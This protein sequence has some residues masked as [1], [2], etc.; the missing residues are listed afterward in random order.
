MV[1]NKKLP[2]LSPPF[3]MFAA[4]VSMA[5]IVYGVG[6]IVK[7]LTDRVY[8]ENTSDALATAAYAKHYLW[9]G[10]VYLL[11]GIVAA[12]L[13]YHAPTRKR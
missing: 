6:N 13:I 7:G 8:F 12:W 2:A 4:I 5:F 10:L 9:T 3:R 11:L 1:K